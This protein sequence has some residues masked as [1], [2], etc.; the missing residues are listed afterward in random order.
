M[1]FAGYVGGSCHA[2][3]DELRLCEAFGGVCA[4]EFGGG[5]EVLRGGGAVRAVPE[6]G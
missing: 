3:R 4:D 2:V 6:E 5:V 1:G